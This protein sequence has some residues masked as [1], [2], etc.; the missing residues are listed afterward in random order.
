MFIPFLL[1]G[2]GALRALVDPG[3]PKEEANQT[4]IILKH[5]IK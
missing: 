5:V 4:Q 2:L 1:W 3:D